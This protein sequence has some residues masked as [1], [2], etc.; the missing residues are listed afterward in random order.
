MSNYVGIDG[1]IPLPLHARAVEGFFEVLGHVE[2]ILGEIDS[3]KGFD[4]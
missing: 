3:R 1:Q 2:H 4:A